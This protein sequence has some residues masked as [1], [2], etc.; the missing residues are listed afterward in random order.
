M[1]KIRALVPSE[2]PM[3]SSIASPTTKELQL[4]DDVISYIA[5]AEEDAVI[6]RVTAYVDVLTGTP[7][8]VRIGIKSLVTQWTATA[9]VTFTAGTT[10]CNGTFTGAAAL[11]V[12][13]IVTFGTSNTLPA[14]ITAGTPYFVVSASTTVITVSATRGGT[15][16]TFATAGTGTHNVTIYGGIPSTTWLGFVDL[17]ANGTNFPNFNVKQWTLSTTASVT[18][19]QYYAVVMQATAG[20]WNST[21]RLRF[22]T[23]MGTAIGSASN[24]FPYTFNVING[25]VEVKT[26]GAQALNFGCGSSTR[27]Y[28]AGYTASS[29]GSWNSASS[30]NQRG[31]KFNLPTNLCTSFKVA[32]VRMG[33]GPTN[34]AAQWTLKLLDSANNV[35]QDKPYSNT[36]AFNTATLTSRDWYFDESTLTALSPNT[37]YRIVVEATSAS[38]GCMTYIEPSSSVDVSSAFIPDGTFHLTTRAGSGAWT[39]TTTNWFPMQLILDDLTASASGG[40][41]VHPGTSGGMRG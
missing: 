27:Q 32:G 9:T 11:V 38:L 36:D 17:A 40:M 41:L 22:R 1:A 8:T 35:L 39:D 20:T 37:D 15:A 19:G 33:V 30:P 3:F 34:S 12:G 31:I 7:G 18:R 25:A 2:V 21:N 28:K 23:S 6:D 13:D 4:L 26:F 10:S 16:I 5:I 14:A 29:I 24:S